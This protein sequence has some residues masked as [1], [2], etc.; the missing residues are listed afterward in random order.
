ML[1]SPFTLE[2]GAMRL[3][4]GH[5]GCLWQSRESKLGFQ[6]HKG[7]HLAHYAVLSLLIRIHMGN[8]DTKKVCTLKLCKIL[9]ANKDEKFISWF[10]I[11]F[12]LLP[13]TQ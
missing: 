12:M 8:S 6:S 7:R 3:A 4:Q 10:L 9:L 1:L 11:E 5:R 13:S 2:T